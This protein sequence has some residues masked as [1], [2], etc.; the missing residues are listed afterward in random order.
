LP[1]E[2]QQGG[3][4]EGVGGDVG[5]QGTLRG[6]LQDKYVL[7]SELFIQ[8]I[9]LKG[10]LLLISKRFDDVLV[11]QTFQK[12]ELV[13]QVPLLLLTHTRY[14][15]QDHPGR[16]RPVGEQLRVASKP[17]Q[18][19]SVLTHQITNIS[20]HLHPYN[21]IRTRYVTNV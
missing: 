10:N 13:L 9:T 19:Q 4:G 21:P 11:L 8:F 2:G 18:H 7:R 20:K 5:K 1:K 3:E 14:Y 15:L 6:K 12:L 16:L 17:Q